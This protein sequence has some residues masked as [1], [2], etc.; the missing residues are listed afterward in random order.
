MF[1]ADTRIESEWCDSEPLVLMGR[2]KRT[3]LIRRT[4]GAGSDRAFLLFLSRIHPK[5]GCDLLIRAFAGSLDRIPPNL[6]LVIAGPD[7]V[8]L[9]ADLKTLASELGIGARIHW[10]GMLKDDLKWGRFDLRKQ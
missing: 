3:F 4:T 6:D 9:T 7:Q 1:F 2:Q 5:K 10:P 8:G